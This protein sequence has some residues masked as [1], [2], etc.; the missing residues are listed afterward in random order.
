MWGIDSMYPFDSRSKYKSGNLSSSGTAVLLKFKT[1]HSLEN[2]IKSVYY[3]AHSVTLYFQVQFIKVHSIVNA[4]SAIKY[5]LEKE[6]LSE[7]Q[8]CLNAENE[9]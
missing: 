1:L 2:Y 5:L 6:Q 4:K 9:K 8:R 3:N 7:R